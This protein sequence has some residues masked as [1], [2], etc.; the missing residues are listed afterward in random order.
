MTS[1]PVDLGGRLTTPRAAAIAGVVFAAL[2]GTSTVMLRL[3]VPPVD[4]DSGEWIDS[5]G[6]LVNLA[7][8]LVPFAGISFLW[9]IGVIRDRLGDREDR[10]FASVMW[11]LVF[12][13]G[14]V[15]V[16]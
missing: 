13:E 7:L 16:Y 6:Y 10:F 12:G 9:F 14:V 2:L 15:M 8:W 5:N 4:G 1:P 3:S 11:V